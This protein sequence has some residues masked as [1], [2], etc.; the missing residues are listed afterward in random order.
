MVYNMPMSVFR[1]LSPILLFLGALSVGAARFPK[2]QGWVSDFAGVLDAGSKAGMEA[3][4]ADLER[5]TGDEIAVVTVASLEG[6]AIEDYAAALFKEWGVGKKGKDNGVL[7]LLAVEEHKVRIEAGYG[8]EGVLPDGLCGEII[9]NA[10]VPRFKAGDYAGGVTD[11]L[12]AVENVLSGEAPVYKDR[13]PSPDGSFGRLSFIAGFLI[14]RLLPLGGPV[15][16]LVF[17]GL[18]FFR[19]WALPLLFWAAGGYAAGLVI[20]SSPGRGRGG[21][22]GGFYGG[23]FGGG[24]GGGGGFGGFGGGSSGGGGASGGW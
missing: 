8:V 4:I 1:R 16:L 17:L 14:G 24:G 7:I 22:G 19:G 6:D 11:G 12:S 20:R 2:S 18:F 3:S 23:G 13:G 15:L 21:Y 5:R 10:M 9:R